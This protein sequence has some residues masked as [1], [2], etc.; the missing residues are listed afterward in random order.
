MCH[1]DGSPDTF[2]LEKSVRRT[3][4]VAHKNGTGNRPPVSYECVKI[5]RFAQDDNAAIPVNA[6]RSF[7]ALRMTTTDIRQPVILSA[8]KDLYV[9]LEKC[10][11]RTVPIAH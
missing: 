7:A 3:V 2:L 8:A 10:V 4:P 5:L 1:G 11:E 6:K 9:S